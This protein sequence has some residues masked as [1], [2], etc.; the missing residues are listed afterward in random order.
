[1]N[2]QNYG[3]VATE[4]TIEQIEWILKYTLWALQEEPAER[5]KLLNPLLHKLLANV[6]ELLEVA[7]M[8]EFRHISYEVLSPE[9]EDSS[10][11]EINTPTDFSK[12]RK[13]P[14]VANYL[15][16]DDEVIAIQIRQIMAHVTLLLNRSCFLYELSKSDEDK[17]LYRRRIGS[18]LVETDKIF[19]DLFIAHP[20]LALGGWKSDCD[21]DDIRNRFR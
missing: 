17:R 6:E 20:E 3:D 13:R 2:K 15:A 14:K 1:M 19:T 4:E 11:D 9:N 5:I 18:L 10:S 7:R 21:W 12:K 16:F 8:P